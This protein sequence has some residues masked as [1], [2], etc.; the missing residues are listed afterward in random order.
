MNSLAVYGVPRNTTA[1]EIAEASRKVKGWG[2]QLVYDD[3]H[4]CPWS[5]ARPG[6]EILW[7]N[8]TLQKAVWRLEY[9]IEQGKYP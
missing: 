3:S 7:S 6:G 5:I 1:E 2:Y 4:I 9:R 8:Y